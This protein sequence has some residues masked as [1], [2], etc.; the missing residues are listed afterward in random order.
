MYNIEKTHYIIDE[1]LLG[2]SIVEGNRTNILDTI[3]ELDK[4]S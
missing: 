3:K 1:M 2:G 4:S